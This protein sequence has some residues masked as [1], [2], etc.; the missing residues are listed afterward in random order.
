MSAFISRVFDYGSPVRKNEIGQRAYVERPEFKNSLQNALETP[1][2]LVVSGYSGAGKSTAVAQVLDEDRT[3]NRVTYKEQPIR[4]FGNA[5]EG[6]NHPFRV[7]YEEIESRLGASRVADDALDLLQA[8]KIAE[9]IHLSRSVLVIENFHKLSVSTG[10]QLHTMF[11]AWSEW[12]PKVGP[13]HILRSKIVLISPTPRI[14]ADDW[15]TKSAVASGVSIRHITIPPWDPDDLLEILRSGADLLN[16]SY[17]PAVEEGLINLSCGIPRALTALANLTATAANGF[18]DEVYVRK[19]QVNVEHLERVLRGYNDFKDALLFEA[20]TMPANPI[21]QIILSYLGVNG[22]EASESDLASWCEDQNINFQDRINVIEDNL[23]HLLTVL[24]LDPYQPPR[25]YLNEL[26]YGSLAFVKLY[27]QKVLP[28]TPHNI[29]T[30]IDRLMHYHRQG[31]SG[32]NQNMLSPIESN[33][34]G[35]EAAERTQIFISYSHLDKRFHDEIR[36]YLAVVED[37]IEIWSD[38]DIEAGE[39]WRVEIESA[40]MKARVGVLLVSPNFLN[41]RFIRENELPPLLRAAESEECRI[42][43]VAVAHSLV[44][45]TDLIRYQAANNPKKPLADLTKQQLAREIDKIGRLILD[46]ADSE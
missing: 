26:V 23:G 4:I 20:P 6:G 9:L 15:L 12:K 10:N 44:D 34:R 2:I 14:V 7:I 17:H 42:I 36:Q 28:P 32:D 25:W 18:A 41:S 40:L 37:R 33:L 5:F 30:T 31:S 43:W 8:D 29:R 39:D 45:K 21:D 1:G 11:K 24:Q 19:F 3:S 16:I 35:I 38:K 22:G 27:I 46:L 13:S